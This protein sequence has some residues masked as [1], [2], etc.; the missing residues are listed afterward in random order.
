[1]KKGNWTFRPFVSSPPGHFAPKTFHPWMY[2]TFPRH[3]T[4]YLTTY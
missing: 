1:L 3:Y 4:F 2:S